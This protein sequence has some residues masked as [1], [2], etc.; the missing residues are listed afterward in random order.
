M[1]F[2]ASINLVQ[3][4]DLLE[5]ILLENLEK[6]LA[7]KREKNVA[8]KSEKNVGEKRLEKIKSEKRTGKHKKLIGL[9]L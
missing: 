6:T 8:E 2:V 1:A 9:S 5:R 7:E 4:Y 3:G